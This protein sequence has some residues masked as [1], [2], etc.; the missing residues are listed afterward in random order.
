[1]VTQ[2]VRSMTE[3]ELRLLER[4]LK[5]EHLRRL[6]PD[7]P[8]E[9]TALLMRALEPV[10]HTARMEE[11]LDLRE[12]AEMT[13]EQHAEFMRIIEAR[14]ADNVERASVVARL[15][16]LRGVKFEALWKELGLIPKE[17]RRVTG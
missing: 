2:M 12:N 10:P 11:L 8:Q 4:E 16:D 17:R 6:S 14:E 9:E 3:D 7:V 5:I 1:M 13:D 15:A